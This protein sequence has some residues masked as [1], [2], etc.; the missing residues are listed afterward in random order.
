MIAYAVS[1]AVLALCA[2]GAAAFDANS[3]IGLDLS[4]GAC[5]AFEVH[6]YCSAIEAL[7]AEA[8]SV[9]PS[10]PGQRPVH[11]HKTAR[12]WRSSAFLCHLECVDA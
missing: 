12:S 2:T 3:D 8:R 6:T 10:L 7:N 1:V 5:S 4:A 11:V 9:A